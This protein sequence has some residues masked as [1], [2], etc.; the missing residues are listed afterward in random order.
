MAECMSTSV[1]SNIS[2]FSEESLAAPNIFASLTR[3]TLHPEDRQHHYSHLLMHSTVLSRH[4]QPISYITKRK[5]KHKKPSAVPPIPLNA[6]WPTPE[7]RISPISVA[8]LHKETRRFD[9]HHDHVRGNGTLSWLLLVD[10]ESLV[11]SLSIS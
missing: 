8:N 3:K 5:T 10:P 2:P 4:D 9:I 1:C 11:S 7:S 6:D